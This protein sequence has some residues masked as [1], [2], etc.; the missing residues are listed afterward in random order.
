ML[1][2]VCHCTR[3]LCVCVTQETLL[4]V[5]HIRTYDRH[6]GDCWLDLLTPPQRTNMCALLPQPARLAPPPPPCL[7]VCP[8]PLPPPPPQL[9][10]DQPWLTSKLPLRCTPLD[11][12]AYPQAHLLALATS[13]LSAPPRPYLPAE[14]GGCLCGGGA[15]PLFVAGQHSAVLR[16][17]REGGEGAVPLFVAGKVGPCLGVLSL[18]DDSS[19]SFHLDRPKESPCPT[20]QHPP[21]HPT[22]HHPGVPPTNNKHPLLAPHQHPPWRHTHTHTHQQVETQ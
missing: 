2:L 19:P 18:V 3:K 11:L 15:V 21:W 17:G 22:H 9:R 16:P 7:P 4:G 20:H 1:L 13:R 6:P 14:P 8:S 10:L 12:T 5:Q